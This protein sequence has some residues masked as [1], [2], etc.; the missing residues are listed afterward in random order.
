MLIERD[1]R[2]RSDLQ[3]ELDRVTELET[4]VPFDLQN[5]PLNR[6]RLIRPSENDPALSFILD[7]IASY[8]QLIGGLISELGTLYGA[9]QRGEGD[10]LLELEIQYVGYAFWRRQLIQGEALQ[11]QAQCW[12]TA[13]VGSSRLLELF[14]DHSRPAQKNYAGGLAQFVLKQQL[15]VNLKALGKKHWITL[16]IA[17]LAAWGGLLSP[18]SGQEDLAAGAPTGDRGQITPGTA[19]TA[20][21]LCRGRPRPCSPQSGPRCLKLYSNG[22][23][24]NFFEL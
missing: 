11:L 8:Q 7:H 23:H 10:S 5:S 19:Y 1:F 4:R 17:V 2:G 16:Y 12:R 20:L 24:D 21:R 9:L 3:T 14:A 13:S 18:V 6:G 15:T 22:R